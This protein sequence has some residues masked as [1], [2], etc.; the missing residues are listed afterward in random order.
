VAPA[1]RPDF[2][3][4]GAQRSGTT[5]LH[6]VLKRHPQIWLPPI[7]ELH[8][9]DREELRRGWDRHNEWL[10]MGLAMARSPEWAFKYIF[11][12]RSDEWYAR[13]FEKA[14]G[15]GFITGEVAPDYAPLSD[16]VFCRIRS[17][18]QNINLIFFMR[19]P[20][21]RAWS[22]V[23]RRFKLGRIRAPLTET[24]ALKVARSPQLA[25]RADYLAVIE[26]VERVFPRAQLHCCFF[27]DLCQRPE[28]LLSEL[29]TFLG[30]DTSV[31]ASMSLPKAINSSAGGQPVPEGFM[32][33]L[34]IEYR[35]IV[36]RLAIRFDGAPRNWLAMYKEADAK[37][38][39]K[40]L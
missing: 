3:V 31:I 32:R 14:Q 27:D 37:K 25:A 10:Q 17:L 4:I 20:V 38:S 12:L 16:Q 34:A 36:Q 8:Y 5:W 30:A 26:R 23:T 39:L 24:T 7:K 6:H 1:G 15:R 19:E 22:A 35:P 33:R 2:L 29:L 21:E 40:Q 9:F 13:L 11:E 28:V 18:N